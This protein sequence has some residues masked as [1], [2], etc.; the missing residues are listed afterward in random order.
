MY[1][2]SISDSA[3]SEKGIPLE[4]AVN[5]LLE[6][7]GKDWIVGHNIAFEIGFLLS[8]C[9][10]LGISPPPFQAIDTVHLARSLLSW[11]VPSFK[12]ETLAQYPKIADRQIHRALPDALITA[13]LYLKLNE[14]ATATN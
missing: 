11:R 8:A 13:R 14:I 5:L 4:N 7:L 10:K 6:F 2:E 12:L 9:R 1:S 3:L